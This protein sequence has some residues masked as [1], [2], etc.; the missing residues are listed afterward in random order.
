MDAVALD[1]LHMFIM[2][3]GTYLTMVFIENLGL[4][5]SGMAN[6]YLI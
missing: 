1:I 3:H 2:L 4:L 6:S 5:L